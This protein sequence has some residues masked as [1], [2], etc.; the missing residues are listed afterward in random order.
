MAT[1]YLGIDIPLAEKEYTFEGMV[2]FTWLEDIY[3]RCK[4]EYVKRYGI[5]QWYEDIKEYS[6]IF[7]ELTIER[8]NLPAYYNWEKSLI[9]YNKK[10]SEFKDIMEKTLGSQYKYTVQWI[11]S[12]YFREWIFNEFDSKGYITHTYEDHISWWEGT[13]HSEYPKY[14]LDIVQKGGVVL[15]DNYVLQALFMVRLMEWLEEF[16]EKQLNKGV[17]EIRVMCMQDYGHYDL[18]AK[19]NICEVSLQEF[20]ES[21]N[22]YETLHKNVIQK[23][24]TGIEKFIFRK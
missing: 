19:P 2:R 5:H 24:V 11:D 23:S 7:K 21:K 12:L 6:V 20:K 15:V 3:I 13:F 4:S 22:K 14:D 16:I 1:L 18:D 10:M 9:P 8:L 17:D